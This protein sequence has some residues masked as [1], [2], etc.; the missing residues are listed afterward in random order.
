MARDNAR[1]ILRCA[2]RDDIE[3]QVVLMAG[4]FQD[5]LDLGYQKFGFKPTKVVT[6]DGALIEDMDVIRDGDHLFLA[7]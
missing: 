2:E 5:L 4:N 3:G 6:E 7:S 1:V